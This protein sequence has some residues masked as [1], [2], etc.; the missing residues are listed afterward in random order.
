[1]KLHGKNVIGRE[2]SAGSQ[3]PFQAVNPTTGETLEPTY[4]EA[5]PSEIDRALWNTHRAFHEYR[6]KGPDERAAFLHRL[7]EEI[8]K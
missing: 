5:A 7:A 1:M 4:H 8:E 3:H 2:T 6:R